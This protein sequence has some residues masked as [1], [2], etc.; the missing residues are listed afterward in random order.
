M[1]NNYNMDQPARH[2]QTS[3]FD[4]APGDLLEG[5]VVVVSAV[6]QP[7]LHPRAQNKAGHSPL[8]SA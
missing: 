1:H 2:R 7:L 6:A 4:S 8:F 3:N 5:A